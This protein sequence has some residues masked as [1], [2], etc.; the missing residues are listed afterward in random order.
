[1]ADERVSGYSQGM[2][3]RVAVARALL[4]RPDLLLLDEPYAGLDAEAK[5]VVDD[6]VRD[7][8]AGGGTVVLSTHDLTR[9]GMAARTVTMESG[10]IVDAP[11]VARP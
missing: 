10:C 8:A 6:L 3:Q 5:E 4:R 1:V 7:T 2:R 9:G 11:E